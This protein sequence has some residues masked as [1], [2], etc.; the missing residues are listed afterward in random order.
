MATK[1]SYTLVLNLINISLRLAMTEPS[2]P[3]TRHTGSPFPHM[4]QPLT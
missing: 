2:P 3:H 1:A 4:P